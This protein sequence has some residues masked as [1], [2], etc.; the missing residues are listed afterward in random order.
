[1]KIRT[2]NVA[3]AKTISGII[4]SLSQPFFTAPDGKGAEACLE[5]IS[6]TAVAGYIARGNFAY[7][8]GEE[9]GEIVG[10]VAV[11]DNRHLY[12]LFV[13]PTCQRRQLGRKLWENAKAIAIASGNPGEF[14]VN[15]SLNAVPVYE[16]FGFKPTSDVMQA[17]G[18]SFLPMAL[19]IRH[20]SN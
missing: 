10:I 17:N 2:A 14:T 8:V 6:E 18:V 9:M 11:R 13:L 15:S 16:S 3:D 19:S 20:A 12:H 1:M 7:Y 5:S 4:R